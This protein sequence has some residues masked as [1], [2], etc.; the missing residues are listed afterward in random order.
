MTTD[1]LVHE[2]VVGWSRVLDEIA[3]GTRDLLA[4]DPPCLSLTRRRHLARQMLDWA[5]ADPALRA[6]FTLDDLRDLST[7]ARAQHRRPPRPD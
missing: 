5:A 7:L 4:Q 2:L 1:D 6:R 3:A